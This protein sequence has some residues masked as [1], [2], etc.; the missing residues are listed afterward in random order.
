MTGP[1]A[2][3]VGIALVLYVGTPILIRFSVK[4]N[5]RGRIEPVDIANMPPE[6]YE[7]FGRTAPALG[8]C[9]FGLAAYIRTPDMV[10]NVVSYVALWVN[11]TAGQMATAVA[12][13]ASASGKTWVKC[14]TEFL[15]KVADGMA[16][17]TNNA[18]DLNSFRRVPMKDALHA[19]AVQVLEQLYRLHL[20]R[21]SRLVPAAAPRYLPEEGQEISSFAE[22][23]EYDIR[24]QAK[25]GYLRE[26]QPGLYR[27]TWVGAYMMTW[28]ELP[29]VKHIR[30]A[31]V[32]ARARR[33]LQEAMRQPVAPPRNVAITHIS[34]YRSPS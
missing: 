13:Y 10:P 29:P 5:A 3:A 14:H 15:T 11:R 2:I 28:G 8:A 20:S 21:E 24:R 12:I 27:Q 33:E 22:G 9:G 1:L 4:L 19:E 6:V 7:Y 31:F 25:V 23:C 26:T 16:V 30:R 17:L 34:P 32:R 18:T